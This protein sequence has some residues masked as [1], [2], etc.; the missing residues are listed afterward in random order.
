MER[1]DAGFYFTGD[2][3]LAPGIGDP[4]HPVRLRHTGTMIAKQGSPKTYWLVN[5]HL[6][7]AFVHAILPPYQ[8]M[9]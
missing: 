9:Y 3:G 6:N 4:C 2:I 5:D 1:L 7:D 8:R